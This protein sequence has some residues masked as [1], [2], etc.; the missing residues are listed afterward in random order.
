MIAKF[1]NPWVKIEKV[2]YKKF[3]QV[4]WHI[5][6]HLRLVMQI[7]S[8]G[9]APFSFGLVSLLTVKPRVEGLPTS[10]SGPCDIHL[11]MPWLC[12]KG[13]LITVF[14]PVSLLST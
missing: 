9:R 8:P 6:N 5:N 7:V 1:S 3:Y 13:T 12:A 11:P 2:V 4:A 14:P 10:L